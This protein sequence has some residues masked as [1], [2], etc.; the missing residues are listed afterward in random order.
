MFT[1]ENE[2]IQA[3][4]QSGGTAG[5]AEKVQQQNEQNKVAENDVLGSSLICP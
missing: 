1:A 4:A 5:E 2:T 3:D